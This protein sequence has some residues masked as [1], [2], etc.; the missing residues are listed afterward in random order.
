MYLHRPTAAWYM[1]EKQLHLPADRLQR[2]Q[3]REE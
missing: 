1:Q 2:V 3:F